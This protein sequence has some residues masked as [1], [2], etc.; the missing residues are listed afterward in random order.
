MGQNIR[1]GYF[2]ENAGYFNMEYGY[3][4]THDKEYL[5]YAWLVSAGQVAA[6]PEPETYA[7]L[8]A[9]LGLVGS[10]IRRRNIKT[11]H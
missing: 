1:P 2:A 9:G 8:L 11:N 10:V 4:Y 5:K 6:V 7:L 3:Q